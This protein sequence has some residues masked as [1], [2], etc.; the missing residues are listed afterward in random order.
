MLRRGEILLIVGAVAASAGASALLL[1]TGGPGWSVACLLGVGAGV[2]AGALAAHFVARPVHLEARRSHQILKIADESLSHLRLGGLTQETARVVCRIVLAE[3]EAKAVAITDTRQILGFAG[4]GEDHHEVGGPILTVAS[5]Q[6]LERNE[7]R[8]LRAREQIQCSH[9]GCPL[10]A[11]IVLPLRIRGAPVGTLKFYYTS[12]RRLDEAQIAMAEGLAHL[13]STQLEVSELDRQT[14]LACRMELKALQAQI[15][16]HFLFNTINTIASLIRTDAPRAR[17]LLRDFAGYYRETLETGDELIPLERELRHV[18]AYFRFEEARFADR[19]VLVEDVPSTHG[20]LRVPAFIVQ[21][22]VENCIR[23]GMGPEG[24]LHVR[25]SSHDDGREV[26]LTVTDDGVGIPPDE[27]GLV[28]TPGYGEG[29]GIALRNVDERLRGHFGPTAG[30]R[31][32]SHEGRG[33]AV[34]LV[35]GRPSHAT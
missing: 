19:A 14:E 32:E 8:V 13:L 1:A 34:S 27:V 5:R 18:R 35:L 30:V 11:A 24:V 3:S 25:V 23:H 15:N 2:A 20:S 26:V 29:I 6:A 31:I 16:P 7:A 17:E 4:I 28:L 9:P 22:L 33:T 10:M 12:P 21:P